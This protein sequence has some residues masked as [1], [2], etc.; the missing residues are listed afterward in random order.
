MKSVSGV[1]HVGPVV[2]PGQT[3]CFDCLRAR[4]N[5]H[6]E[7]D[8]VRGALDALAVEDRDVIGVLTRAF[9]GVSSRATSGD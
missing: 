1:G 3:A 5:A 8:E 4:W 7:P 9:L 2:F 6:A